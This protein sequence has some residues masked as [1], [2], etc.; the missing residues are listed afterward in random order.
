MYINIPVRLGS[1]KSVCQRGLSAIFSRLVW[2]PAKAHTNDPPWNIVH[3][4]MHPRLFSSIIYR[5]QGRTPNTVPHVVLPGCLIQTAMSDPKSINISLLQ[6]KISSKNEHVFICDLSG[7]A[8]QIIFNPCWA[9]MNVGSE[10]PIAWNHSRHASSWPFY[11]H[12]RIEETCSPGIICIVCHQLLRHPW[13][14][15]TSSLGK[16]FPAKAQIAELKETTE[17]E[18]TELTSSMVDETAV[19]ILERQ[20]SQGITILSL[21]KEFIFDIPLNPY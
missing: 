11:L 20:G 9:S 14:H 6:G 7:H 16:Y 4:F 13:E 21:Q 12:C 3:W 18:V 5:Y 17:S 19:A 1:C 15:G 10:N 8:L 2:T